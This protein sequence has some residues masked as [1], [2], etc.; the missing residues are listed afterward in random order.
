MR[1]EGFFCRYELKEKSIEPN[2]LHLLLLWIE[3]EEEL[4]VR[5]RAGPRNLSL[6]KKSQICQNKTKGQ[7]KTLQIS[8]PS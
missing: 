1:E 4:R 8:E 3:K 2:P 7:G 5:S 6:R